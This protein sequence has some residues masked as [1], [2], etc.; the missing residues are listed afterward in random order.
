ML[1]VVAPE[2]GVGMAVDQYLL[3][4]ECRH[5]ELQD[6]ELPRTKESNV[7]EDRTKDVEI[8]TSEV[9]VDEAEKQEIT[10]THAFFANMGGFTLRILALSPSSQKDFTQKDQSSTDYALRASLPEQGHTQND[11]ALSDDISHAKNASPIVH[12]EPL[13]MHEFTCPVQNWE[14]LGKIYS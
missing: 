3:A 4:R 9:K 14:E 10:N 11:Q 5:K 12:G 6:L 8:A 13:T 1:I 7:V 2:I